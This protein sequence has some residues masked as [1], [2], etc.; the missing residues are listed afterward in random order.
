MGVFI[1]AASLPN[2]AYGDMQ[3]AE[4]F[5]AYAYLLYIGC[6]F[7]SN[8]A[9]LLM[10]TPYSKLVGSCILPVLGAVPD[11]AIV[12]FS[13][14]GPNAQSSLDV[15]VGA[16]AG[17]TVMLITIPW[18]VSIY[19]GLVNL[20]ENGLPRYAV[21]RGQPRLSP[22]NN[23]WNSGVSVGAGYQ[24]VL[25][26]ALWMLLTSLPYFVI[27]IGALVAESRHGGITNQQDVDDDEAKTLA[28][29]ESA[30]A[31]LA[32]I[33]GIFFFVSYLFY[34]YRQAYGYK[35]QTPALDARAHTAAINTVKTGVGLVAA[36]KPVLEA[37]KHEPVSQ[38]FVEGENVSLTGRCASED[39]MLKAVLNPF[40][41]RYDV[42]N[43]K[44]LSLKE[45]GRVFADMNEPKSE[46]ELIQIFKEYDRDESGQLSFD[47]F[48]QGMKR[49]VQEKD[50]TVSVPEEERMRRQSESTSLG[51]SIEN[52]LAT[53][54]NKYAPA[55]SSSIGE[56]DEE[57]EEMPEEFA[58]SK[59]R[60]VKDQ[61]AAI[62]RTALFK[63][64][65]GT[66][67]V[68]I[69]SDPITDVLDEIG[70]RIGVNAFYVGFVVAPVITNGS[71]LLAAY[72]FALKK[73]SKSMVIAYEQLLGAAVMNNTYCLSI[74]LILI[75]AQS[76]YWNYT[77]E[78]L[79]IIFAEL[80]VF[81][82]ITTLEVHTVKTAIAIL[83]L[84]P[85]TLVIVYVLENF[86][87]IS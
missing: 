72:T 5:V 75:Y 15:G 41:R 42:D 27:E 47:E 69:F 62:Q 70:K 64:A 24:I 63:C 52:P 6:T 85:L 3:L 17:S 46:L 56:E 86:V 22:E 81:S 7:I 53:M 68:L 13:G 33:L 80:V 45:L 78:V 60:S 31:L 11:G 87:G 2:T 71:E 12:L 23:Y 76:L 67:L 50:P 32:L 43:S 65:L 55:T 77:A 59:F 51:S 40:F 30:T 48:C 4:L 19:G 21:A 1:N 61:Q 54:G 36:I 8:G 28:L 9:E 74:F 66:V 34:Q 84:Y 18:A 20:D 39:A 10:L 26:M 49:Y 35:K 83:S 25:I 37:H 14:L 38:T 16:L 29:Q 58:E 57:E 79:A 73:T 82:M 44:T